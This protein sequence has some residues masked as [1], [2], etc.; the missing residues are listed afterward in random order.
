[1]GFDGKDGDG[2]TEKW[3]DIGVLRKEGNEVNFPF[4]KYKTW[5]VIALMIRPLRDNFFSIYA[6]LQNCVALKFR[7]RVHYN[8]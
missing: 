2:A 6:N 8:L 1:M 7:I 3:A 4:N 5:H